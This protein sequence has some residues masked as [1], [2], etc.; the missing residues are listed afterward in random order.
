MFT[1]ILFSH[2][3]Y[4]ITKLYVQQ[5]QTRGSIHTLK[6]KVRPVSFVSKEEIKNE[7]I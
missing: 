3:L 4:N 5:I 1:Q 6:T 2:C 7:S